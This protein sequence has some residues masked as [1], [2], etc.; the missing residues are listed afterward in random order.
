M[1]K[2]QKFNSTLFI[3]KILNSFL[4][5]FN[6]CFYK[7][8]YIIIIINS[9]NNYLFF[10]QILSFLKFSNFFYFKQLVDI[11]G[12]DYLSIRNNRFEINYFFV[13]YINYFCRINLKINLINNNIFAK[14]AIQFYQSA[15]WAEREIWD[16]FGIYF[17]LNNDL[18]RI[19]TDYGFQGYPLRKDFPLTGYFEIYYSEIQKNIIFNSIKLTQ[20]YRNFN[21][22]NPWK[23]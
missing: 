1:T 15:G 22:I 16:L 4:K 18:R 7:N 2:L 19:L 9:K 14:S 5:Y 11:V 20:D 6:L 17:N 12:V 13:S 21:F 23:N 3:F 8:N 10:L